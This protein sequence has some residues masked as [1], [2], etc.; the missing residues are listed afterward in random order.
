MADYDRATRCHMYSSSHHGWLEWPYPW[1]IQGN[2]F[3]KGPELA[4]AP[5]PCFWKKSRCFSSLAAANFGCRLI[6]VGILNS[7]VCVASLTTLYRNKLFH[8]FLSSIQEILEPVIFFALVQVP[9]HGQLCSFIPIIFPPICRCFPQSLTFS[10]S[11]V[12]PSTLVDSHFQH[13]PLA[14]QFLPPETEFRVSKTQGWDWDHPSLWPW[15]FLSLLGLA[16]QAFQVTYWPLGLW[17]RGELVT[18]YHS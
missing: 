8:I 10:K 14:S 16:A 3:R 13:F 17:E 6:S 2:P 12:M 5:E 4:V 18:A 15:R 9:R 1:S 7:L 11:W